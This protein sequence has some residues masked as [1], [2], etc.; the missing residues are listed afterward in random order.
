MNARLNEAIVDANRK[1]QETYADA[2][3]TYSDILERNILWSFY[4]AW[5]KKFQE[6]V[7]SSSNALILNKRLV[8][9]GLN[10][11]MKT[12]QDIGEYILQ[13]KELLDAQS[14]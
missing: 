14:K 1:A 8:E 5:L 9:L 3:S 2:V 4:V 11:N 12:I 10:P 7:N 6:L 13:H